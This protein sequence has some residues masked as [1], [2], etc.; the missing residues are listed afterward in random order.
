MSVN[1]C[2]GIAGA[3]VHQIYDGSWFCYRQQGVPA[4]AHLR[5]ADEIR[6]LFGTQGVTTYGYNMG[7]QNYIT[8]FAPDG[9]LRGRFDT[10]EDRGTWRITSDGKICTKYHRFRNGVEVW[11]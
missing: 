6:K 4:G 7:Y 11:T 1:E 8:Y 10:S 5:T 9:T 3:S 2:L